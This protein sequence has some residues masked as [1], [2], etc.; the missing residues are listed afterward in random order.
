MAKRAPKEFMAAVRAH[1]NKLE[2]VL[3]AQASAKMKRLYDEAQSSVQAN[4]RR[5]VRGGKGDTFTA[6][7]QRIVMSQ[8]KQGQAVVMRRLAGDMRPLSKKAQEASLNGLID[9]VARLSKKFTGAEVTLPVEEAATFA[10]VIAGR[11]SSL[12][13]MHQT[14]MA[15]Y[16]VNVVE[17]VEEQ[18]SLTLL[19]GGSMSDAYETVAQSIDGEWWQGERIV[20]TEMAYAYNITARDGIEESAEEIP[21]LMQRWEE[22]CDDAGMPLDDRV[23]VDSIAMHGQV[24]EAGG[25]FTMPPT[26][27]FADAKGR[28]DVPQS[29][30]GL[31]WEAPPNRPND[32][33]VISPW[34]ESWGVPG[35]V[36]RGGRRDW[37]I[38]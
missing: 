29:L 14:S 2:K 9:D 33:S 30:V 8:L 18:L 22:H 23:A 6:H 11:S 28:T 19:K 5:A 3:T 1:R 20:R 10:D 31:S 17:N 35:W 24:T 26:A 32:R 37:L 36:W 34:M 7:Q 16:G 25:I 13:R 38:R 15:R 27:P 4:I 21:E 12:L